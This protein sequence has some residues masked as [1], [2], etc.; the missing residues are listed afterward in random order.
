MLSRT[1]RWINSAVAEE[2]ERESG[3]PWS[4]RWKTKGWA[5]GPSRPECPQRCLLDFHPVQR[6]TLFPS[7]PSPVC[8]PAPFIPV[9]ISLLRFGPGTLLKCPPPPFNHPP[10][11]FLPPSLIRQTRVNIP[12][13]VSLSLHSL[14]TLSL[15]LSPSPSLI[16][17]TDSSFQWTSFKLRLLPWVASLLPRSPISDHSLPHY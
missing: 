6:C 11:S 13:F 3:E 1:N 12:L 2:R 9:F 16:R 4:L 5:A 10:P 7:L 8:G 15:P 14:H 17:Y